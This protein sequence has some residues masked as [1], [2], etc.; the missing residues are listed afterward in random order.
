MCQTSQAAILHM[1]LYWFLLPL[2]FEKTITITNKWVSDIYTMESTKKHS[3]IEAQKKKG[4]NIMNP[5]ILF[6]SSFLKYLSF[7]CKIFTQV[8]CFLNKWFNISNVFFFIHFKYFFILERSTYSNVL[9]LNKSLKKSILKIKSSAWVLSMLQCRLN[10][11]FSTF[12]NKLVKKN[13]ASDLLH[14]KKLA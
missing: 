3:S 2:L 8:F 14:G 13:V 5:M 7:G 11:G 6:L 10:Y 4:A 1:Q 9:C 12:Y